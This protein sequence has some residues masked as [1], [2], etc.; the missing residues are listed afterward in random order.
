MKPDFPREYGYGNQVNQVNASLYEIPVKY[1]RGTQYIYISIERRLHF[2]CV[3]H[4]CTC[5]YSSYV[6]GEDLGETKPP[7][8]RFKTNYKIQGLKKK[9]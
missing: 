7:I 1:L 5:C 4:A 8:W 9:L 3:T 6:K 2:S